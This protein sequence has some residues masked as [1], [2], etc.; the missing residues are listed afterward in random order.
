MP[1]P[2]PATLAATL[3]GLGQRTLV[4]GILNVTPDSFSDGGRF[5]SPDRAVDHAL[6]MMDEGADLIDVGGETT[7]P[8]SEP[9]SEAVEL[10][11]VVPVVRALAARGIGPISVDTTKAEVARRALEEGAALINDISAG[12][13][14]PELLSV[15]ARAG[16]PIVLMHTRGRPSEMQR[17][18]WTYEGGVVHAVSLALEAAIA[19]AGAAGISRQQ[20]V[21]DPGIGFGKTIDE[22][23]A[24]LRGLAALKD[25][26]CPILVGTSRKSFLGKLTGKEVGDRVFATASTV[27]LAIAQGAAIVRVHDVAAMVDVARVADAV[28]GR[29]VSNRG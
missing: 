18:A 3:P 6:A 20:I 9:V 26:G 5:L 8:G 4:M 16:A 25:L 12:T 10:S 1:A 14:E 19:R 22:N 17:G 24:L 23:L 21:I 15:V 29:L 28:V 7:R 27:A 13:F 2:R 11:R